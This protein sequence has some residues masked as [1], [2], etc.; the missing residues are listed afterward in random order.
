MSSCT[1]CGK[2]VRKT[3]KF[4]PSCGCKTN[5]A[6]SN[7]IVA[8][9]ESEECRFG[10]SCKR[11]GCWYVHPDRTTIA[12]K[13]GTCRFGQKCSRKDCWYEHPD[14][15]DM[16]RSV[17]SPL[18][19]FEA[20]NTPYASRKRGHPFNSEDNNLR[21]LKHSRYQKLSMLPTIGLLGSGPPLHPFLPPPH[22]RA[23][24][25]TFKPTHIKSFKPERKAPAPKEATIIVRGSFTKGD[26]DEHQFQLATHLQKY[27]LIH[28][29]HP[30]L[31]IKCVNRGTS[32]TMEATKNLHLLSSS[33]A[34]TPDRQIAKFVLVRVSNE[35]K[36]FN[37]ID[38]ESTSRGFGFLTSCD[39]DV[40]TD[41][42][43]LK[44]I[45][46]AKEKGFPFFPF[47][48]TNFLPMELELIHSLTG[49]STRTYDPTKTLN[50]TLYELFEEAKINEYAVAAGKYYFIQKKP[51]DGES[52]NSS[53]IKRGLRGKKL[54]YRSDVENSI[55]CNLPGREFL[56]WTEELGGCFALTE[57]GR[58]ASLDEIRTL[59]QIDIELQL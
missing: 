39:P 1:E 27:L 37:Q 16:D 9:K 58:N 30:L 56:E 42:M 23:Q 17:I 26:F 4:C 7:R 29:L 49:E 33:S 28:V 21:H 44:A 13:I 46:I 22:L 11:K 59:F 45:R 34:D 14:G 6:G 3:A 48:G 53:P 2:Q 51:N 40:F 50:T 35:Y 12:D 25:K 43:C 10:A 20:I 36:K 8:N 52:E 5:F 31:N 47:D 32:V 38:V 54:L 24:L 41:D 57:Y 18:D 55:L 15:R 19:R